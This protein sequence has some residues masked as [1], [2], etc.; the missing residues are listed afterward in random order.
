MTP[1]Q[2]ELVD[3]LES[4]LPYLYDLIALEKAGLSSGFKKGIV[5]RDIRSIE[6]IIAKARDEA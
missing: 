3:A 6:K 2:E 5:Q 4:T 1:I